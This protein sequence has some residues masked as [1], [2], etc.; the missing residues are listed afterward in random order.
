METPATFSLYVYNV[1]AGSFVG[2]ILFEGGRLDMGIGAGVGARPKIKSSFS[3]VDRKDRLKG[4]EEAEFDVLIIGG[5]ITGAGIALDAVSR[6]LRPALV[7]MQD[8]AAGTSSRSTKLVHG[9]LRYLKNLEIGVVA[10]VGQERAI[11]YENGPHVTTPERML[12]PIYRGGTFGKFST[13]IG[14]LVYDFL[15]RVK[16]GE[17]RVMLSAEQTLAKEPLLGTAGLLGGGSYVEYRTDDAR[18]TLEVLKKAVELGAAAVNYTKVESL[19]YDEQGRIYGAAVK[20]N[21]D[22]QTYRIKAK[23]VVNATGPWVDDLRDMD[24]SKSGKTLHL[25][26]GVHIVIDGERFPLTQAVY[27]DTPDGRM[28]FAIPREGKVYVGTTDTN[29]KGDIVNPGITI[30]DRDYLL[31]AIKGMFPGL[32]LTSRDVESGWSG[33]RPLIHQEGK[34]PSEISRRDEIF[35]SQSGLISIAGGKLTGYRKMAESIVNRIVSYMPADGRVIPACQTKHLTLSGGDVGGSSGFAAFKRE[36]TEKGARLGL[37]KREAEEL[38]H[39]YG[40]NVERVF[41]YAEN[42]RNDIE[43]SGLPMSIWIALEYAI[44]HEM[45]VK[46]LDFLNRRTGALLFNLS[47]ALRY[48]DAVIER[49]A[50]RLTYTDEQ[51]LQFTAELDRELHSI[52]KL[53]DQTV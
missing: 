8:Y 3:G 46:P 23:Y 50:L 40:S 21:I 18:L 52:R 7:D 24:R 17:R 33:L 47:W 41:A 10:E 13:S 48:K 20:D 26:K 16:R 45:A 38:V 42:D 4:M 35:E 27:F 19:L 6:G 39:R 1:E 5:G 44:E 15:A 29:Y 14:L 30:E 2:F 51:K 49:M 11:V 25:T 22:E 53:S 31:A 43:A 12:L 28:V 34:D 37:E 32:E 36:W 9:G